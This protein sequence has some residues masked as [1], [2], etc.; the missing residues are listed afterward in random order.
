MPERDCYVS[1]RTCCRSCARYRKPYLPRESPTLNPTSP[2][3][4]PLSTLPPPWV[5]H[6]QPYLPRE[7]PTLN[8]TSTMSQPLSTLLPPWVTHSQPNPT[9]PMSHP[10]FTLPP[11]WVTHS[12]PYLPVSQS[13]STIPPSH[14]SES[15]TLH[16]TSP[17]SHPPYPTSPWVTHSLP[18][19]PRE[20]NTLILTSLWVIHSHLYFPHKSPTLNP[21]SPVSDP[22]LT[23][24]VCSNRWRIQWVPN[25]RFLLQTQG[26]APNIWKIL[27]SP[28]K[29]PWKGITLSLVSCAFSVPLHNLSCSFKSVKGAG[30]YAESFASTHFHQ[31]SSFRVL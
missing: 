18:Y 30:R 27:D 12:L 8:P 11:P 22:L 31:W 28:L 17:M 26:S 6:S 23:S 15:A 4:H 10:L 13:L 5:N 20:S 7:S 9:S 19:I 29:L 3:S 25:N 21:T 2:V 16:P 24:S 1:E 14:S